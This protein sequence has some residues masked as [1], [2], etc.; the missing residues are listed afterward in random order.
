MPID[1]SSFD[2]S[3]LGWLVIGVAVVVLVVAVLR[4]FG[5]L[6]HWL[7]RGCGVVLLMLV[8]LYVLRLLK[9]I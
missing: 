9:V 8:V 6:L 1:I 5:H 4:L 3:A 2:I 7:I